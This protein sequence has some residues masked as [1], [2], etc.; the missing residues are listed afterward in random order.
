MQGAAFLLYR[1]P[2]FYSLYYSRVTRYITMKNE[3]I[4]PN[5]FVKKY[6]PLVR[7]GRAVDIGTGNGSNALFLTSNGFKV[8]AIDIDED[9]IDS[10]KKRSK[11]LKI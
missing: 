5:P 1:Q 7:N 6:A 11:E 4:P 10:I 2:M 8:D 3:L 9:A